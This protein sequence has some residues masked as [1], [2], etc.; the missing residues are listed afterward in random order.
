MMN[1]TKIKITDMQTLQME[2]HRLRMQIA[3]TEKEIS[4]KINELRTDYASLFA[5]AL[6]FS[7]EQ[8]SRVSQWLE[9]F[10]G[11]LFEKILR[12]KKSDTTKIEIYKFMIRLTQVFVVRMLGKIW[13]EKKQK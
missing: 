4:N 12:G 1:T 7:S 8:N 9:W 2:K 5:G 3:F 10:N 13:D 11:F 6:P